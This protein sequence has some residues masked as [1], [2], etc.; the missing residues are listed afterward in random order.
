MHRLLTVIGTRPQ[1]IKY[2][3]LSAPLRQ[4][5][6]EVLVDTGQH[7]D[8]ALSRVFVDE[9]RLPAPRAVLHGAERDGADRLALWM[10]QLA[11]LIAAEAPD[12]LLCFGDTDS[13]LAAAMA[14]VAA[15]VPVLHVEAGERCRDAFGHRIAP[16]SMPEER[17]RIIIDHLASLLLCATDAAVRQCAEER[18]QGRAVMVGD[19]MYDVFLRGGRDEAHEAALLR[20]HGLLSGNFHLC[21]IHRAVN[22]D[23]ADRLAS[24]LGTLNALDLPVLLPLHPRTADRMRVHGIVLPAG[25]LRIVDPLPHADLR[26]VLHHS[27]RVLT[28]SGGLTREA[29]FCG[30]PSLCLDDA[31][32]WYELCT[33]GW[34]G[35]TGANAVRIH[36]A[37]QREAPTERPAL[38][39][40]G[41]AA[42]RA[43]RAIRAFLDEERPN[44]R[45]D[46]S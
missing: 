37:L 40:D 1:Y 7:Y 39:G 45:P 16:A 38:F 19:V 22:T 31:T 9:Y 23:D 4:H 11:P 20:R 28:D 15:G 8:S 41:D 29:Y 46:V 5:V 3:A 27:R 14:G 32:A 43:V 34:C 2:A 21:T 42:S 25:A 36:A 24:L 17:N 10:D 6:E 18:C 12:A 26:A 30:I 13:A 33:L 44:R 35:I